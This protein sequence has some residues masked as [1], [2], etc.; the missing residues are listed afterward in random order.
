[1]RIRCGASPYFDRVQ[2]FSGDAN[3]I[4]QEI[5]RQLQAAQSL[6]LAF[7]DPDGLELNWD[8]VAEV[9]TIGR[10]DLIIHYPQMGL[11]RSMPVVV[12]KP[13][14]SD[15]DQF[16]GG[17]EWRAIYQAYRRREEGFIHR[18]LMDHYKRKLSHLG[19][20]ETF[21]DDEV[22]V[23][24]LISR[25]KGVPLYRLL[26]ASKHPLGVEFWSKITARDAH[27]QKR[28]L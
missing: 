23:E 27:G 28:M 13:G 8:T 3:T 21:R 5:V 9:A 7:L 17:M 18:Q 20:Q 11:T 15:V 10:M 12:D 1:M 2:T 16:F 25:E 6:N 4:V 24:P 22:G 19:Y 26:F 14:V